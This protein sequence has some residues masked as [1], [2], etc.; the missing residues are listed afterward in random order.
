[1]IQAILMGELFGHKIYD[2]RLWNRGDFECLSD[3]D[4]WEIP[5]DFYPPIRRI[6]HRWS[7][8]TNISMT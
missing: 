8:A 3:K 1:M 6:L 4:V 7:D 2:E 5:A